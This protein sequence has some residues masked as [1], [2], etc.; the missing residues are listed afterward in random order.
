MLDVMPPP[1][2][3][4]TLRL[5]HGVRRLWW[6]L[7]RPRVD[8]VRMIALD[9]EGRVLLVRHSYGSGQWMCPGGGLRRGENPAAA[10]AREFAEE[11]GALLVRPRLIAE[12]TEPLH[13]ATNHIRIVAGRVRGDI[14]PDMRELIAVQLFFAHALP[15]DM[16]PDYRA[17]LTGWVTAA[18]AADRQDAP[19]PPP[20]QAPTA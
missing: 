20:S 5:I 15:A 19:P 1:L 14:R 18:Q 16:A 13:G 10:A 17:K 3:R 2:A 9:S 4:V 8:G 12:A 11:T 7:R 6:G